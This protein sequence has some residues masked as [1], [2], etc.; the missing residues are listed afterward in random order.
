MSLTIAVL[1]AGA[2]VIFGLDALQ[3]R[4]GVQPP[5]QL[6]FRVASTT[7]VTKSILGILTF[8]AFGL[9]SFKGPKAPRRDKG[10]QR[11]GLIIGGSGTV[12]PGLRQPPTSDRIASGDPANEGANR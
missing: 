2:L 6:A 3:V 7:A 9:A 5:M 12:A 1:A 10:Q 4:Q 8:G 11:S